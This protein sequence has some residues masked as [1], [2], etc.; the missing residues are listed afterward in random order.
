MPDE[1][2]KRAKAE[3]G[4]GPQRQKCRAKRVVLKKF[5][6]ANAEAGNTFGVKEKSDGG[7]APVNGNA[8]GGDGRHELLAEVVIAAD[9]FNDNVK[10]A[11]SSLKRAKKSA[12]EATLAREAAPT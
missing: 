7:A 10:P 5:H 4:R 11:A 9:I 6:A 8:A 2:M 1:I 12:V 3:N